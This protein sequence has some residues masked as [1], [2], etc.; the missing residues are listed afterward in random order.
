MAYSETLASRIGEVLGKRRGI[1]QKKMFG[2]ICFFLNGNICV[3]VW[4][5]SLIARLGPEQAAAAWK[6]PHVGE[7]DV[8]GRPMNGWAMIA[9][10]GTETDRQLCD[11]IEQ[12][13]SFVRTLP[14]K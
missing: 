5:N 6:Q 11:W 12:A 4:K 1:T 8:T 2:S 14:H 10:E 13:V 9:P 3:G 7:F